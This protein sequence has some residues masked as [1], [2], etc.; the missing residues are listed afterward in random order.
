MECIQAQS[1]IH[2]FRRKIRTCSERCDYTMWLPH[3]THIHLFMQMKS[4]HIIRNK[5]TVSVVNANYD[6]IRQWI[7]SAMECEGGIILVSNVP[8]KLLW[9]SGQINYK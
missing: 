3:T 9:S 8:P 7:S 4:F 2:Q 1:T 6:I 5:L